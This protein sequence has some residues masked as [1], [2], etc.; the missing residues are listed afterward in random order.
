MLDTHPDAIVV[1][2]IGF[3]AGEPEAAEAPENPKEFCPIDV[4]DDQAWSTP[5]F[6]KP[7]MD[8]WED[9][10]RNLR[11]LRN[12]GSIDIGPRR[13]WGFP[14]R[15]ASLARWPRVPCRCR[16][17]L[18]GVRVRV[19]LCC[20]PERGLASLFSVTSFSLSLQVA[21]LQ[22]PIFEHL[23]TPEIHMHARI[24]KASFTA[25]TPPPEDH[26]LRFESQQF[27][28]LNPT[29]RTD[30][31]NAKVRMLARD[32]AVSGCPALGPR[33]RIAACLGCRRVVLD[34]C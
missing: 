21:A 2:D 30:R 34:P 33:H 32:R 5:F 15:L 22:R 17:L 13:N 12:R 29:P 28:E 26:I 24:L 20:G 7:E 10:V 6:A 9:E 31:R 25:W 14:W 19:R 18:P 27:I 4:F 1:K 3:D 8:E 23:G 16:S 11:N